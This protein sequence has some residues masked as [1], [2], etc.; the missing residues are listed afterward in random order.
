MPAIR[1]AIMTLNDLRVA[2]VPQPGIT[3]SISVDEYMS[4]RYS[5]EVSSSPGIATV[6][7]IRAEDS[8]AQPLAPGR[9]TL[10]PSV[11]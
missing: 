2:H 5:V 10:V 6:C 7:H 4:T 9:R 8:A 11:A 3:W 1:A